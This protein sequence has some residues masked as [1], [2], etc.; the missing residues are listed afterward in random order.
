MVA[1]TDPYS[2][3]AREE[4]ELWRSDVLRFSDR[5][6][7]GSRLRSPEAVAQ[8]LVPGTP[9]L[10]SDDWNAL[11]STEYYS[12]GSR[13]RSRG[14]VES[15]MSAVQPF[16]YAYVNG[17]NI[18]SFP[19]GKVKPLGLAGPTI[20][21]QN[22]QSGVIATVGFGE[23]RN[24]FLKVG[25]SFQV[26]GF[27]WAVDQP[28]QLQM[29][30]DGAWTTIAN[31]TTDVRGEFYSVVYPVQTDVGAKAPVR[32][33]VGGYPSGTINLTNAETGN[34]IGIAALLGIAAV[35]LFAKRK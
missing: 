14:R 16:Q 31:L 27:G 3:A 7:Q 19:Y 8:G 35:A 32:A 24:L 9:L 1:L 33:I 10:F 22:L 21:A 30:V 13:L 17:E 18:V 11:L 6:A 20:S 4:F 23:E 29:L 5:A 25:D 34:L 26:Y 28:V 12:G 2:D 15:G